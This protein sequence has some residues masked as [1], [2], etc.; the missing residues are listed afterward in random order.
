M[1]DAMSTR[2]VVVDG[3]AAGRTHV[4]ISARVPTENARKIGGRA[5]L[6]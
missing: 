1:E 3:D 5:F 4:M 6:S 2:P